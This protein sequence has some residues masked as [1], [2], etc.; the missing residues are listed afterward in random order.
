MSARTF[1]G[2]ER[3]MTSAASS[4]GGLL[5]EATAAHSA[6]AGPM[7]KDALGKFALFRVSTGR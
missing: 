6:A 3:A 1:E 5:S 4:E 2:K 7:G